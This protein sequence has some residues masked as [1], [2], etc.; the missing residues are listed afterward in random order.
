MFGHQRL[1]E[2][3]R[4]PVPRWLYPCPVVALV[5]LVSS[6]Y[7]PVLVQGPSMLPTLGD[8]TLIWLDRGWYRDHLPMQG[9]VVVFRH[10]GSN[11]VKRVYRGPGESLLCVIDWDGRMV[12]V[13]EA[14]MAVIRRRLLNMQRRRKP[15]LQLCRL[16]VPEDSIFVL[17]DNVQ[18]SV[19]SRM[20][21]FIPLR[22]LLGRARLPIDCTQGARGEFHVPPMREPLASGGGGKDPARSSVELQGGKDPD[23]PASLRPIR[24]TRASAG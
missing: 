8:G 17:G 20:L 4:S 10:A 12:P 14:N 16:K 3:G 22:A 21:G 15:P 19:D 6:L 13:R 11:Y 23:V 24:S 18:E 9:E 2:P 5:L 1:N 7:H